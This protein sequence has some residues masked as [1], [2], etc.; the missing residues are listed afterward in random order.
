MAV[1]SKNLRNLTPSPEV[2]HELK[3]TQNLEGASQKQLLN[4][5]FVQM[6]TRDDGEWENLFLYCGKCALYFAGGIKKNSLP[7]RSQR[8]LTK[9]F[10]RFTFHVSPEEQ[11]SLNIREESENI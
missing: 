11:R 9:S 1:C 7:R 3:G 8:L 6:P 2:Q 10:H 5:K 4:M